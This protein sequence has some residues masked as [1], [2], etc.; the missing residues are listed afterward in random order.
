MPSA[1]DPK[2]HDDVAV[3]WT[4]RA[5]ADPPRPCRSLFHL[6][7]GSFWRPFSIMP[8]AKDTREHDDVAVHWTPRAGADPPRPCRSL[9]HLDEG[10]FWRPFSIMP[11]AKDT[12]EH[13]DVAVHWTPRAGAAPP[14]NE[15]VL[16]LDVLDTPRGCGP[17]TPL[18]VAL[19]S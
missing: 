18:P 6:D 11:S 3:H 8:S 1:K 2:R 7:E 12:R 13:D 16:C 14:M 4:P 15:I 19:P 9:F 5:G 17:A 10:S